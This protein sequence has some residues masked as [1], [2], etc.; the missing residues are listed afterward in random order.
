MNSAHPL[1][2]T[3]HHS[4]LRGKLILLIFIAVFFREPSSFAQDTSYRYYP[5]LTRYALLSNPD[6]LIPIDTSVGNFHRLNPAERTFGMLNNG[7]AGAPAEPMFLSPLLTADIDVGFHSFDIYWKRME[8]VKFY[9][10]R[11]PYTSFTYE[12]GSRAEILANVQ[13]T[14]SVSKNVS[15]G[16]DFNRIRTDGW[17]QRQ[18]A[19]LSTLDAFLHFKAN[20]NRYYGTIAYVLNTFKVNENG[21]VVNKNLFSDS[22]LFDKT[23][24]DVNL[25]SAGTTWKNDHI[26]ILNALQ[27]GKWVEPDKKDTISKRKIIPK[28]R[29]QHRFEWER[30]NYRFDDRVN[31]GIFYVSD[32]LEWK[33]VRDSLKFDRVMNELQLSKINHDTSRHSLRY[34][35]NIFFR[36]E[37]FSIH[38]NGFDRKLQSG[39]AGG[40]IDIKLGAFLLLHGS[41]EYNLLD[42]NSGDYHFNSSLSYE[43][44][45]NAVLMLEAN[46][47]KQ[48]PTLIEN[49]YHAAYFTIANDFDNVN[50]TALNFSFTER[51][52]KLVAGA[53]F[54]SQGNYIYWNQEGKPVQLDGSLSGFQF[55]LK[56]DFKVWQ[57]HLD[58]ELMYQ[59]YNMDTAISFPPYFLRSSLYYQNKIFKNAMQG[60]I[61]VDIRYTGDYYAPGYSGVIGQ[62][63]VQHE[64]EQLNAILFDA[65]ISVRVRGVHAF[66]MFQNIFNR[67]TFG[68]IPY[69]M[70]DR[71]FKVG[72]QW[73][74]WD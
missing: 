1:P 42:R 64:D 31:D 70:P 37:F 19:K 38:N 17:Y 23:L 41:L 15:F 36:H 66:V 10:T 33:D 69:P 7:F 8:D 57:F 6:S 74:F 22:V 51:R 34:S 12:Q 27:F 5:E 71:S 16:V 73:M 43:P 40:V 52:W 56:K 44:I 25:D 30:R 48:H 14:R 67:G 65:F 24:A 32:T 9:N 62:Y 21:G 58:N 60:K 49:E 28:V 53:A 2:V 45:K 18:Q 68:A 20:D 39:I 72:F 4:R 29:L 46:L 26:M 61:G 50:T 11:E 55:F 47:A 63:T 35:G 59:S 54:I 3:N 13:H